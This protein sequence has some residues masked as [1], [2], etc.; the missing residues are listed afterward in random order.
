MPWITINML[1]G[2]SDEMKEKLHHD[3]T[4]TVS[5]VLKIPADAIAIQLV[6]MDHENYSSGGVSPKKS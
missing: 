6:E 1:A 4:K 3:V 5:E 2:R